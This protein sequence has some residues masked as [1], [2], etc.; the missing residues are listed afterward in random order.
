MNPASKIV[1]YANDPSGDDKGTGAFEYPLNPVLRKGSLDIV[2]FSL[3][4]DKMSAYFTLKFSALSNPGWHPEYGFQLTYIAIAIDED[5]VRNSGKRLV[6][7]N[8]NYILDEQYAYEKLV[9][10]GGG[11]R[12]EDKSGRILTA[13]IPTEADVKNPLGNTDTS[14]ISFALPLSYLGIPT[15]AWRFTILVGAQDDHGGSGLGE[16]RTV[17]KE[18]GEWSGGGKRRQDE[19]NVYDV[20][21]VPK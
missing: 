3:S 4:K 11:V 7:Q 6:E 14:T 9:L 10:V 15:K 5:R 20:L 16:F 12:L 1:I 18:A 19:P 2:H 17:N 21:V 13:Y 8:A